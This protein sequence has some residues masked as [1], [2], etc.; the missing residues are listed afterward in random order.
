[1]IFIDISF[2]EVRLADLFSS[3]QNFIHHQLCHLAD[4]QTA[5]F[6]RLVISVS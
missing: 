1:M 4:G 6:V 5:Q 2:R 3:S